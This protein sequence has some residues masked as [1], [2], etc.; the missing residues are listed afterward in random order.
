MAKPVLIEYPVDVD[1]TP[2]TPAHVAGEKFIVRDAA[3]AKMLHPEADILCYEDR[4]GFD[5]KADESLIELREALAAE[6]EKAE[7]ALAKA[8]EEEQARKDA[9]AK[10]KAEADAKAKAEKAAAKGAEKP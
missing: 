2:Y 4:S 10:A 6:K 3:T 8:A 9:E 7:A 5:S 1:A